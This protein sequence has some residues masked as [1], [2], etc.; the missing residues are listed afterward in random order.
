MFSLFKS[1]AAGPSSRSIKKIISSSS[2]M[3]PSL[4]RYNSSDAS[5]SSSPT[6]SSS[7]PVSPAAFKTSSI[8]DQV[9]STIENAPPNLNRTAHTLPRRSSSS[10]STSDDDIAR[11]FGR[12]S[13]FASIPSNKSY[14]PGPKATVDEL[15][16]VRSNPS[17]NQF[18]TPLTTTTSRSIKTTNAN[19][20]TAFRKLNRVLLENNVRK[21]LRQQE[22]FESRSDK[23]VR[24]S[25]ERHRRRFKVAVGRA[26]SLAIRSRD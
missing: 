7:D 4:L 9:V 13:Q 15:W 26:V 18:L 20:N 12:S 19:V 22:R 21:E 11:I 1:T 24:L 2:S 16:R 3:L 23:R 14:V 6:S 17:T 25:S 10:S 5:S 8:I